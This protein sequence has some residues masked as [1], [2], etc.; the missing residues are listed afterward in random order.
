M[1]GFL[2]AIHAIIALLLIVVILLQSGRSGGLTESFGAAAES[3]FGTKTNAFMV[4]VT[5]M[6]AILFIVSCLVLAYLSKQRSKSVMERAKILGTQESAQQVSKE[7]TTVVKEE[8][9]ST[10]PKEERIPVLS[11]E[12][13]A[14]SDEYMD[15]AEKL[16]D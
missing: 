11:D 9:E 6:L 15:A 8:G 10:K 5:T 4:R 14:S 12:T 13:A 1:Y 2:I 7:T 16:T 3:L